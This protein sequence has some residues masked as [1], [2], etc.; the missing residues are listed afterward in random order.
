[1]ESVHLVV[2]RGSLVTLVV[3]KRFCRSFTV[4]II[5]YSVPTLLYLHMATHQMSFVVLS[6]VCL[7]SQRTANTAAPG[8]EE[9]PD[10]LDSLLSAD[11]NSW[12]F[13]PFYHSSLVHV[14]PS[15]LICFYPPIQ[16]LFT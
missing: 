16:I 1:M 13:P 9:Q 14:S 6:P 15:Q 10:H 7:V 2:L 3:L 11:F 12:D 8:R 4:R 5:S